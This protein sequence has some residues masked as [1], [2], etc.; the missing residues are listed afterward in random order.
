MPNTDKRT[1]ELEDYI[2]QV[3]QKE[4]GKRKKITLF[5]L[6]TVGVLG[7]GLVP[8]Y[9]QTQRAKLRSFPLSE[10]SIYTVDSLFDAD[11]SRIVLMDEEGM[12]IDTVGSTERYI[13]L[14][15]KGTEEDLGLNTNSYVTFD[16]PGVSDSLEGSENP[17][18]V[19]KEVGTAKLPKFF[20]S[21]EGERQVGKTLQI[22]VVDYDEN[23]NYT[24]DFGNGIK[25]RIR[26]RTTYKYPKPGNF[27]INLIATNATNG[28]SIY[29]RSISIK[30]KPT[31][32]PAPRQVAERPQA[33]S[34]P[35]PQEEAATKTAEPQEPSVLA[36]NEDEAE[37]LFA[38]IM[39]DA[40]E[41]E[42]TDQAALN[43]LKEETTAPEEAPAITSPL[44][45]ADKMPSFPGGES[46]MYKFLRRQMSYPRLARQ[47]NVQ[48]KV[49]LQF[50]VEADGK[51][52]NIKVL[53][54]IGYGC[55]EEAKRVIGDMP[56]WIPGEQGGQKV[57]VY[58]TTRVIFQ[59]QR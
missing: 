28:S 24:L 56:N 6:I 40:P 10:L 9:L 26:K 1:N 22:T 5:S 31:P 20:F 12:V 27:L 25:R 21:I 44:I 23:V 48:G 53:R 13:E 7:V 8:I 54:G 38:E 45:T 14:T 52:T 55:D 2:R 35:A 41:E 47:K 33:K 50:V 59:L 18:P 30:E 58:Y 15:H 32:Q 16:D 46:A 11:T 34:T 39:E 36:S 42:G 49:Y 3:E 4:K 29:T 51:I 57:P 37:S 19:S 17:V 43:N